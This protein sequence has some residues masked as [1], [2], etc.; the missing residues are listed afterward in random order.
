MRNVVTLIKDKNGN[1]VR[2]RVQTVFEKGD[3]SKTQTQHSDAVNI[4]NVVQRYARTNQLATGFGSSGILPQFGVWSDSEDF[5]TQ[6]RRVAKV[7]SEFAALPAEVRQA[8]KNNPA[9]C[10]GF[11][12]SLKSDDLTPEM[13]SK[14]QQAKKHGLISTEAFDAYEGAYLKNKEVVDPPVD[15]PVD[16]VDNDPPDGGGNV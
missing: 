16:P 8:Y 1:V 12:I 4:N 14:M 10:L 13:L 5:V 6:Q 15:P 3:V 11:T 9:E 2:R 7:K